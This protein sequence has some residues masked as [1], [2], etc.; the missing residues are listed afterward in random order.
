ML[1][2]IR[3]ATADAAHARVQSRQRHAARM[4][5]H[6][7]APICIVA[8]GAAFAAEVIVGN[9]AATFGALSVVPVLAASLLRSRLLTLMVAA[10]AM[11]LQVWGVDLGVVSRDAAGMQISVYLL[12]LAVAALQQHRSPLTMLEQSAPQT[13][14]LEDHTRAEEPAVPLISVA[15]VAV[16]AHPTTHA[17]EPVPAP[18]PQA[19]ELPTILAGPLTRREQDVVVLAAQGFTAREIGAHLF[20]GDRT[21]ETHLANAYGKLGVHSKM[22]LVRLVTASAEDHTDLRT[23]TE[24]GEGVTA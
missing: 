21:V 8:A 22:E 23:P 18:E 11:L 16:P 9:D 12:I 17:S 3:T 14:S 4:A 5:E 15:G 20:I 24:A 19:T 2:V 6:V 13:R 10:F 1:R 7:I